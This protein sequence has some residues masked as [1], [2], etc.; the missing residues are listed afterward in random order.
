MP[1]FF[2]PSAIGP[3]KGCHLRLILSSTKGGPERLSSGPRAALGTLFHR[4]LERAA[5]ESGISVEEIFEEEYVRAV[6][7]A[8]RDPDQS[9]FAALAS[10]I[11]AIEW[12]RRRSWVIERAREIQ[13]ASVFRGAS[14]KREALSIFGTEIHLRS[15][16]LRIRGSAD[17]I[18]ATGAGRME[19]RDYKSGGVVDET[20]AIKKDIALQLQAYGLLVLER[21]PGFKVRLIVD[22]GSEHDVQFDPE[23]Q[24]AAREE[25]RRVTVDMPAPGLV[26]LKD[27][28]KP[29][30]ACWGCSVRH[31]C[32]A[33][34]ESAVHWWK[35][36]PPEIKQI[37]RD[38]WG[39][40]VE[41]PG[42]GA[43]VLK[44]DSG[45]RVRISKLDPRHGAMRL[46]MRLWL[47]GLE[48]SGSAR[49]FDGR[50]FQPRSFHELPR[51]RTD[52][53]AWGLN[54]FFE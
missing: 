32:S 21:K 19:V 39:T 48:S 31:V 47:F 50:S 16:S 46:G 12:K 27:L 52:R 22:D 44:D 53:R 8:M 43:V 34:R 28:A 40:V 45:R 15:E 26:A 1:E 10:T 36:I 13:P 9:H 7:R 2:S 54:V 35:E 37:P 18:R 42:D 20:G 33:Y 3:S 17:R 11:P 6:E 41:L 5:R 30:Q 49:A 23:T 24:T 38:I 51:D 4:V 25:I 14:E 29:G